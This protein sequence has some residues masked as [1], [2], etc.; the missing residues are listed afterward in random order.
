[1]NFFALHS[2][3]RRF[4]LRQCGQRRHL[5]GV[6]LDLFSIFSPSI[7]VGTSATFT[8]A[9]LFAVQPLLIALTEKNNGSRRLRGKLEEVFFLSPPP[10]FL[11]SLPSPAPHPH[12]HPHP[13]TPHRPSPACSRRKRRPRARHWR[14][15]R[16]R[17]CSYTCCTFVSVAP[18]F[19]FWREAFARNRA[20]VLSPFFLGFFSLFRH[21]KYGIMSGGY[22]RVNG[23]NYRR[24]EREEEAKIKGK[25]ERRRREQTR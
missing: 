9:L 20:I 6:S 24:L 15:R 11:L 13:L 18:K 12:K 22:T 7:E 1:M 16:W 23:N 14:L 25:R 21:Y 10:P 8:H 3:M 2:E 19:K 17:R 5:H 4:V